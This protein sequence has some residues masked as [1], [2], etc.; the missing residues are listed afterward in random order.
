MKSFI[1]TMTSTIV[2]D[3]VPHSD[4]FATHAPGPS[5][6]VLVIILTAVS[7]QGEGSLSRD[8][9]QHMTS[10]HRVQKASCSLVWIGN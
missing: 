5:F 7:H 6:C 4:A 3:L 10:W 8:R 1:R 9:P 2:A